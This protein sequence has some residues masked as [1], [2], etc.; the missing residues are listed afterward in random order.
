MD[1]DLE[2]KEE[3]SAG[4]LTPG[5]D[6]GQIVSTQ[7]TSFFARV[8]DGFRENPNARVS[9]LLVD[10]NGKPLPN[11]PPAQP[12]LAMKL[13][14]R[15]LQMIA[16]GGSIGTGLFVG[17]GS[18]L[19][20]GG[21]AALVLAYCLLGIMIFCTVHALGEMA[22]LFPVAG[23][24]SAYSSR[25]L[26]PA[27]GF[28]M[29]W[30]YAFQWLVTLPIEIMAASITLNYWHGARDVNPCVWVTIFYVVI[31]SIN[32]FGVKGYGEAE[33]VFSIIKVIATLGF[34]I[35]ALVVDVGGGP[36]GHYFGAKTWDDPG[37]FAY[38]FKG[39]CSVFVTA[40]FS[41]GGTELVGLAAAEAENPRL[42]LPT[43]IKQVFWRVVLFYIISLTFVGCLVRWDD[44]RLLNSGS[45]ANYWTSPFVLAIKNAGVGGLPS[46]FNA[47]IL[48]AVLSVGNASVY[49][50]SRTMAALADNGQ[51]PK[52]LGYID[53]TGRPLVAIIVS[54]AL[55]ALCY[56]VALSPSQRQE[57]WNWMFAVSG[58]ASIFTWG[59]ICLCHIRFRQAWKYHGHTLD[60][61]PYK[62]QAG[63]IGSW[64]G[65]L[66]NCLV[67][68]AQFWTGFA[69]IGYRDMSS[70]ERTKIFFEGYLAAP[71]VLVFYIGFKI[72]KRTPIRRVKDI[73][74]VSGRRE[75]DLEQILADERAIRATWPWWKK[76]WNTFC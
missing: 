25:F 68:I 33:F 52:I 38:G 8:I 55:G 4:S 44:P 71:I 13:K 24:Y 23:S 59:S 42:A 34:I 73:D 37:A 69:P 40:A 11:Q 6:Y 21:P 70:S 17:S 1:V 27:W 31:I 9:E 61:L 48:I 66:F 36:T 47:V 50:A 15:H 43:A 12:A 29:G 10:D 51:A 26:D 19:A 56:I 16:I 45:S 28:A 54:S 46:V 75:I 18:A 58:L 5:Q 7:K 72:W 20:T 32:L 76:T 74:V 57:A 67:L 63:V 62:S 35:F 39:V 41:F 22:V 2:K 53:R 65:F 14:Q 64:I 3:H 60:E 49:G 30:N